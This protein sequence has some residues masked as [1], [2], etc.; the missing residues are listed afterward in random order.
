[1]I[2][3]DL[4][5]LFEVETKVLSQAVRINIELVFTCLDVLIEKH[6]NPASRKQ[7]DIESN[8]KSNNYRSIGFT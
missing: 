5:E 3:S 7:Q 4:A 6:E 1:M 2:D 8:L